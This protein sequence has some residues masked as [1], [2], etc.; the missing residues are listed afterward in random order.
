MS[1]SP[2]AQCLVSSLKPVGNYDTNNKLVGNNGSGIVDKRNKGSPDS[3]TAPSVYTGNINGRSETSLEE[4]LRQAHEIIKAQQ[5]EI[6]RQNQLIY[7]LQ[8]RLPEVTFEAVVSGLDNNTVPVGPVGVRSMMKLS[9]TQSHGS[10]A[11][12]NVN[13]PSPSLSLAAPASAPDVLALASSSAVPHINENSML[14][15]QSQKALIRCDSDSSST[16]DSNGHCKT[17]P[18]S[19]STTPNLKGLGARLLHSANSRRRQQNKDSLSPPTG[20]SPK[21]ISPQP[22]TPPRGPQATE[23]V[24]AGVKFHWTKTYGSENTPL[25]FIIHDNNLLGSNI[26]T[27]MSPPGIPSVSNPMELLLE[28]KDDNNSNQTTLLVGKILF[29]GLLSEVEANGESINSNINNI[30]VDTA[31]VVTA[32]QGQAANN[33]GSC[34]IV[35]RPNTIAYKVDLKAAQQQQQ[36]SSSVSSKTPRGKMKPTIGLRYSTNSTSKDILEFNVHSSPEH[37][38]DIGT[39]SALHRY[40]DSCKNSK[41]DVILHPYCTVENTVGGSDAS[42]CAASSSLWLPYWENVTVA[43]NSDG[44]CT[45]ILGG[46]KMAPQFRSQGVGYLRLG[47][48]MSMF[49]GAYLSLDAGN[50]FVLNNNANCNITRMDSNSPAPTPHAM[51]RSNSTGKIH[52]NTSSGGAVSAAHMQSLNSSMTDIQANELF[53][54]ITETLREYVLSGSATVEAPQ[55]LGLQSGAISG[56]GAVPGEMLKWQDILDRVFSLLAERVDSSISHIEEVRFKCPSHSLTVPLLVLRTPKVVIT[57]KALQGLLDAIINV[58]TKMKQ[59]NPQ[60]VMGTIR[61]VGYLVTTCANHRTASPAVQL[62][63]KQCLIGLLQLLK[64]HGNKLIQE[65]VANT[66]STQLGRYAFS[67]SGAGDSTSLLFSLNYLVR[68]NVLTELFPSTIT[69]QS[70]KVVHWLQLVVSQEMDI[71]MYL[72]LTGGSNS[73]ARPRSSGGDCTSRPSSARAIANAVSSFGLLSLS[74]T[75]DDVLS[76]MSLSKLC[77]AHKDAAVREAGLAFAGKLIAYG[78][79]LYSMSHLSARTGNVGLAHDIVSEDTLSSILTGISS[80]META[81]AAMSRV[82]K[83]CR[84]KMVKYTNVELQRCSSIGSADRINNS[85]SSNGSNKLSIVRNDGTSTV[86]ANPA[87]ATTASGTSV[88][89]AVSSAS[90]GKILTVLCDQWYEAKLSLRAPLPHSAPE[91]EACHGIL[92]QSISFFQELI[93]LATCLNSLQRLNGNSNLVITRQYLFR[94]FILAFDENTSSNDQSDSSGVSSYS[95]SMFEQLFCAAETSE[96][97]PLLRQLAIFLKPRDENSCDGLQ[98]QQVTPKALLMRYRGLAVSVRR[99]IRVKM[100]DEADI[101]QALSTIRL[102]LRFLEGVQEYIQKQQQGTAG[103]KDTIHSVIKQIDLM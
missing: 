59:K 8:Q 26:A 4:K 82:S 76:C 16:S 98:V 63:V 17:N 20:S 78:V 45:G 92:T 74:T 14:H 77:V 32:G 40:L 46:R 99:L 53:N 5:C 9:R 36:P 41:V 62:A 55:Y 68:N 101:K 27:H 22:L 2:R 93:D 95:V 38:V 90:D 39:R 86:A 67:A 6:N 97:V 30:T 10:N 100:A 71:C 66:L 80:G 24:S 49:G 7:E 52:F 72:M 96:T 50:T 64:T 103:S 18:N 54:N 44:V 85:S 42:N 57:D 34:C 70:V 43:K 94:E 83:S 60:V 89:P 3:I 91:W 84:E 61:S 28:S 47:D 23:E 48:D 58:L 102:I 19:V 37:M 1:V 73:T 12:S 56:A 25:L 29:S 11:N 75:L 13:T 15:S 69:V 88:G 31:T 51:S 65:C 33:R 21:S 81:V 35:C 79:I 87:A